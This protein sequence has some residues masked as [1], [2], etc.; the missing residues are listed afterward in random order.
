MPVVTDDLSWSY[1]AITVGGSSEYYMP[2]GYWS[3]RH[4][5]RDVE[6]A[7]DVLVRGSTHTEYESKLDALL[8]ELSKRDQAFALVVNARTILPQSGET[9]INEE[10]RAEQRGGEGDTGL[11]SVYRIIIRAD[12]AASQYSGRRDSESRIGV[13]YQDS[14]LREVSLAV[15]Y[16]RTSGAASVAQYQAEFAAFASTVQTAL[17]I[18]AWKL[19]RESLER[20][21]QDNI[22]R[23]T[24]VY[25]EQ[26]T[27]ETGSS[28]DDARLRNLSLR[29]RRNVA[30]PGDYIPAGENVERLASVNVSVNAGID[31]TSTLDE[32]TMWHLVEDG[33]VA[34]VQA[35][36]GGLAR[37]AL[38][39]SEPEY[40]WVNNRLRGRLFFLV[41]GGSNVVEQSFR[42]TWTDDRPEAVVPV[43][44]ESGYAGVRFR[45]PGRIMLTETL[46]R[47]VV[48]DGEGD[49]G[50]GLSGVHSL[51][52]TSGPNS[53]FSKA[54]PPS[55]LV[56]VDGGDDTQGDIFPGMTRIEMRQSK[57]ESPEILGILASGLILRA[58]DETTIRTWRIYSEP[59]KIELAGGGGGGGGPTDPPGD[60]GSIGGSDESTVV[61]GR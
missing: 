2:F 30:G 19:V 46:R 3:Y 32:D 14:R 23:A 36:F 37:L 39:T 27:K 60:M 16:T 31:V 47:R 26:H 54:G 9:L 21:D 59:P 53:A 24:A 61:G 11:S 48:D 10:V 22:A 52:G 43:V 12:R 45:G 58:R 17:G 4:G 49:G 28:L 50:N 18:T 5:N 56:I 13:R 34:E 42:R 41:A 40:D 6:F 38:M 33:V 51:I 29:I 35:A 1:G 55:L 7:C 44:A 20:D 15:E 57:S 8:A 25:R